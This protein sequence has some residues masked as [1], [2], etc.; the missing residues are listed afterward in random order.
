MGLFNTHIC[1]NCFQSYQG[2][3]EV[4]PHCGAEIEYKKK[5]K[6]IEQDEIAEEQAEGA[7][8]EVQIA[9]K[10]KRHKRNRI[11]DQEIM[12]S[13]DFDELLAKTND[14]DAKTWREKKKK[15]KER[16]DVTSGEDGYN[17][18]VRDVSYLPSTYTYSA[19]K[20]R[21][22][23]QKQKI[24]WWE[25]YKW[26]DM[27]LAR[28]KVKK[29]VNRASHYR[30][31]QFGLGATITLCILFGWMGAHNFYVRNWRKG[32]FTLFCAV[33]GAV[34]ALHPVFAPVKISIGGGLLF[35]AVFIWIWD[36]I[37]LC[38]NQ[39]PYRL[40]KWKFIDSLNT[41]TRAKLGYKYVD[42]DEYKRA[43]IVRVCHS[44]K[45]SKEERKARREQQ[46]QEEKLQQENPEIE[47]A[48]LVDNANVEEQ[49]KHSEKKRNKNSK[50][51][52]K[53]KKTIK[54]N[55]NKKK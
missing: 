8:G 26:A 21:G 24:E 15:E 37:N 35:I 30:P 51:A 23:Y 49:K 38:I 34:V 36:L 50:N 41:D 20:A 10:P 25:I 5:K 12:D 45:R 11:S 4:C 47:H 16:I 7:A 48:N 17:V 3:P 33:F 19:K 29:Q 52:K 40:S 1:R 53:V 18:D 46:A 43:W 27:L 2:K 9:P 14:K 31:S 55:K 39:F 13:I 32:L 6:E 54:I 28:R 44:I 42:K 22:E